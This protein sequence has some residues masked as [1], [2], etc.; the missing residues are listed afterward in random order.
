[1]REAL[2]GRRALHRRAQAQRG[3]RWRGR[4]H[5]HRHAGRHV[6]YRV[7][8]ARNPRARR[9]F[10]NSR[11]PLYVLNVTYPLI[12]A[13][14]VRFCAPK[15]AILIIE[16]GQPECIEQAVN[17]TLRRADVATRIEG[18]SMLPMAGEYTGAVMK[19]GVRKFIAAYRGDSLADGGTSI[20]SSLR[21]ERLAKAQ[22]A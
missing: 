5:R 22:Q 21:S 17:T 1:G 7:A 18:K 9:R 4:R 11:V 13:E 15:K 20:A 14:L 3:L 10:G 16:E 8:R 2:A 19:D 12:D 6:Q